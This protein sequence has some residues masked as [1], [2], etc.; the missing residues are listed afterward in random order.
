M[1]EKFLPPGTHEEESVS[2][3]KS[4]VLRNGSARL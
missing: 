1:F 4:M 2:C 3:R